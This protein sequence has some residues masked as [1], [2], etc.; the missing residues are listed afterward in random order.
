M[1][2]LAPGTNCMG[3][4]PVH[5][6]GVLVDACDYYRAFYLSALKARRY[7]LLAGWQFD[8]EVRLLRG[9]AMIRGRH[10]DVIL[11]A[12]ARGQWHRTRQP[13][14]ARGKSG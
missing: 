2:I 5:E 11:Y 4:Y 7:I 10:V 1:S 3:I 6:T 12:V 14:A 8:S 13:E 9:G